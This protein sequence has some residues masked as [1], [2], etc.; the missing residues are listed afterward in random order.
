M[1]DRRMI[2]KNRNSPRHPEQ[3]E[4]S[5][6]ASYGALFGDPSQA[7]DDVTNWVNKNPSTRLKNYEIV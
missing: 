4:G 3:R 1:F 6:G 7:R 2:Q 5:P